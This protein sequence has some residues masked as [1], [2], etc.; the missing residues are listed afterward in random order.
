MVT[1]VTACLLAA[2]L[3]APGAK[4]GEREVSFKNGDVELKGTIMAPA[5]AGKH[6]AVVF[7]HGSGPSTREGARDYAVEFAKLG[8][9]SLFF[10]K[11]GSG[12]SGGS[13]MQASL[14]DLANDALAAVALLEQQPEVD[15]AH[16]GM[17]GVSQAGWVG[18]LAA[19]QSKDVAFLI[20]ITGGGASPRET[21]LY[22]YGKAFDHAGLSDADRSAGF[23][24]IDQYFNYL[25]TGQGRAE[26][27]AL[28]EKSHNAAWYPHAR[29]D[30]ILPSEEN[31]KNW[32]W[33]ASWDPAEATAKITCPILLMFGKQDE[34]V[35]TDVAVEKW[36]D[37]LAKAG[38]TDV[39]LVV[40]PDA[41]HSIRKGTHDGEGRAPFA[42]GY[43]ELML[44]WLW[45][46]VVQTML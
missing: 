31:R 40:F 46:H 12:A 39:T 29:L 6:P 20:L 35:P 17:W 24:V 5:S 18:T 11:R 36:R 33:V 43:A 27:A 22:A 4:T 19:S 21:E 37:G 45:Y 34:L 44:G 26:L 10:D 41:G 15:A 32:S 2:L 42:D 25:A 14:Q 7:L 8:I 9:V 30:R 38:N 1:N 16:I 23:A 13:W 3:A 28:L